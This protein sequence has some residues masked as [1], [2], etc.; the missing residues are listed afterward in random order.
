MLLWIVFII[1]GFCLGL[2]CCFWKRK[3]VWKMFKLLPVGSEAELKPLDAESGD[4][5]GWYGAAGS[6]VSF[7]PPL[8]SPPQTAM[9]ESGTEA[10]RWAPLAVEGGGANLQSYKLMRDRTVGPDEVLPVDGGVE[11]GCRA[12]CLPSRKKPAPDQSQLPGR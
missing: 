10:P 6:H 9:R 4:G 1:L 2:L 3:Q 5:A 7:A 12:P 11:P 8:S